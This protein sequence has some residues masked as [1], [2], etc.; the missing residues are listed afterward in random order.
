M[1]TK[2]RGLTL[3]L[4]SSQEDSHLRPE[5]QVGLITEQA[6]KCFRCVPYF[7]WHDILWVTLVSQGSSGS[8]SRR[9]D[10]SWRSK[11]PLQITFSAR[12]YFL[13]Y[14]RPFAKT[15]SWPSA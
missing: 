4:G 10:G 8:V 9:P 11:R 6:L 5:T 13:S 2:R 7:R 1:P 12:P 14:V 15:V 3:I